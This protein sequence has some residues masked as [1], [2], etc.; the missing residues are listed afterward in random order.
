M[1]DKIEFKAENGTSPITVDLLFRNEGIDT[2]QE[3]EEFKAAYYSIMRYDS[4]NKAIKLIDDIASSKQ[5][6]SKLGD[7]F[8]ILNS[9]K[10]IVED[11]LTFITN[12]LLV[13]QLVIIKEY[14]K[15]E[16]PDNND[17]GRDNTADDF[18]DLK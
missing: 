11:I 5:E 15:K 2:V 1:I 7:I 3:T 12:R 4:F 17:E 10:E 13:E 9:E 14:D 18:D 16:E 6:L 8:D